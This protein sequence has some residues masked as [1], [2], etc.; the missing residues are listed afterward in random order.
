M[1]TL[2]RIAGLPAE[3]IVE[4]H[5]SFATAACIRCRK[6]V[7]PSWIKERVQRGEIARCPASKCKSGLVKPDIV[8]T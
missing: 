7:S 5:G 3:R 8:C 6:S 2:E 4:A 1:D